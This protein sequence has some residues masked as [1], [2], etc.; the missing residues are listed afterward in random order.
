M[1]LNARN[2]RLHVRVGGLDLPALSLSG[3]EKLSHP[4][5]CRLEVL[6]PAELSPVDLLGQAAIV[7]VL[8]PDGSRRSLCGILTACE[9]QGRHPDGR[10]RFALS[11]ES[12]LSRL[13]LQRDTRIF[14]QKSLPEILFAILA[15]HGIEE[16]AVCLRLSRPYPVHPWTLQV[17]ESDLAFLTR[18]L[19]KDGIFYWSEAGPEGEVLCF[20]DH[21]AQVPE[22]PGMPLRY[23]PGAGLEPQ[24]CGIRSLRARRRL[25]A[26]EFQVLDRSAANCAQALTASAALV[27][28][29]ACTGLRRTH[30]APGAG[31]PHHA[32][33]Q[34][35][36]LAEQ[37]G[38]QRFHLEAQADVADLAPG[39]VVALDAESF[40]PGTSGDYLVTAIKL[41]LSQPAGQ[42]AAGADLAL[43]C[44][45]TLIP[46]A[47]S[48]RP[49]HPAP[50]EIPFTFSARIEGAGSE[51]PLD[52]QGRSLARAHFDTGAAPHGQ[53]SIPL[54]R[55]SPHGGLPGEQSAGLHFPLHEGAEV[56][57]SCLNN[58]P[59]RPILIGAL[60]NPAV[61]NP[62]TSANRSQNL[63]RTAADN[64][65]LM[66]D[67]RDQE[68]IRLA[69]FAGK[70][71]LELNA[72]A[73]G[74]RIALASHQGAM[75]VQA[76]KTQK[77]QCGADLTESSG[78]DRR[79]SILNRHATLTRNGEIH[80][81]AAT[82]Q[83]HQAAA[84][85]HMESARNTEMTSAEGLH[86]DVAHNQK[87]TVR[88]PEA[89]FSVL[90]GA[91]HIQ[92]AKDINIQGLGGGDLTFA[93]N[94]GG[95]IV[96]ADG[97]V[98]IFGKTVTLG[99]Q[100]GASLNG[101]TSYQICAAVP[102]PAVKAAQALKA[103][104]IHHIFPQTK[105]SNFGNLYYQPS[106]ENYQV[107]Q[108]AYLPAEG[109]GLNGAFIFKGSIVVRGLELYISSSGF[110]AA[111]R[112]GHIRFF[113]TATVH[114][115]NEIL[116]QSS[117]ARSGDEMWAN[118]RYSPV[119]STKVTLPEPVI[120]KDLV[121]ELKGGYVFS[122]L[123]GQVAPIPA[124]GY[125]KIPIRVVE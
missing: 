25:T 49:P 112:V 124:L 118:D 125:I 106:L 119:G 34:A 96:T 52:E 67:A 48:F 20:C 26:D 113:M 41:R 23:R 68:V 114:F 50:P 22:R 17:A 64:H 84:G 121:L 104:G 89:T 19:A 62:V 3:D 100:G 18:L 30:F 16:S 69:T 44:D 29:E 51:A 21:N 101:P 91:I 85:L 77:L 6:A 37:A 70:N 81:Q 38:V 86:F 8:G 58:D 31:D 71:I 7:D 108:V 75:Q 95:F 13:R 11:V 99:G 98:R 54:R 1:P 2:A 14:L 12:V 42:Q 88:G 76:K 73:L 94:G 116:A 109:V 97:R 40:A 72:Q 10:P 87:L 83:R 92:S 36:I 55:L 110:T 57:L 90:N 111:G 122:G 93:Q 46:R 28:P 9:E 15:A 56:L 61:R 4:F 105:S 24:A 107:R 120:G 115:Q 39:S 65:L 47:T 59:D 102:M 5:C 60:P 32:Q 79:Q 80:H 27:G 66:D 82:D 103:R 63:L 53:A 43:S 74:Q 117:F 45:A 35:Q 33:R 123:G 78:N